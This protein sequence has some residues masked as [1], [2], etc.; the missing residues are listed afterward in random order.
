MNNLDISLS[1]QIYQSR[2][3]QYH[4]ALQRYAPAIFNY[5]NPMAIPSFMHSFIPSS[6]PSSPPSYHDL[7][8]DRPQYQSETD[9]IPIAYEGDYLIGQEL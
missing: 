1:N 4:A 5:E 7:F 8:P 9:T 6:I 2:V 3:L